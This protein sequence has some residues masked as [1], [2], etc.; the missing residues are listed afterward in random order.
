MLTSKGHSLPG[1]CRKKEQIRIVKNPANQEHS[2]TGE[3]RGRDKSEHRKRASQGHSL[4]GGC[5][6]NDK[7]ERRKKSGRSR[8]THKLSIKEGGTSRH[9]KR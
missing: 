8:A 6:E 2:Q 5:R 3:H 7:S 4:S 1:G 9:S